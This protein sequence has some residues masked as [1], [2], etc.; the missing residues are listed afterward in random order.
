MDHSD[1]CFRI[2]FDAEDIIRYFNTLP[3]LP[4]FESLLASARILVKRY[5]SQQA[6]ERALSKN[7]SEEVDDTMKIPSGKLWVVPTLHRFTPE[8]IDVTASDTMPAELATDDVDLVDL[9]Q[10]EDPDSVHEAVADNDPDDTEG[11]VHIE[12]TNFDGD[13]VLANEAL[14]LQD[15][16][17][18][19]E[20]AYAV[21]EGD[22][23]RLYQILKVSRYYFM[24]DLDIE[25]RLV[26]DMDLFIYGYFKSKLL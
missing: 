16:G 11:K 4:T 25:L 9:N 13:R 19:I 20:A 12:K 2:S 21:P 14:F 22:V 7:E 1:F 15:H 17:W 18:W 6:H 23:G 3:S 10:G 5:A 24:S 26:L 8:T